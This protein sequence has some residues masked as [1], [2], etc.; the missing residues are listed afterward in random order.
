VRILTSR[1]EILTLWKTSESNTANCSKAMITHVS[2]KK[3]FELS[4][5]LAVISP[6]IRVLPSP[7]N[8]KNIRLSFL[9]SK[10]GKMIELVNSIFNK[11]DSP[12]FSFTAGIT[13]KLVV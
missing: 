13:S 6:E 11:G 12:S 9:R 3:F 4:S 7:Q 8:I 5:V 2:L 10:A 1:K